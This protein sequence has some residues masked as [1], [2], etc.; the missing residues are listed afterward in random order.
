MKGNEFLEEFNEKQKKAILEENKKIFLIAGAGCG[1]TKTLIG[2]VNYLILN[3]NVK[4]KEILILTF[5]KKAIKEIKERIIFSLNDSFKDIFVYNFHSF[6]FKILNRYSYLIGFENN[7]FLVYDKKEQETLIKNI[8]TNEKLETDRKNINNIIFFIN[9]IKNKKIDI[10]KLK[11]DDKRVKIYEEYEKYF[12]KNKLFDYNDLILKSLKILIENPNIRKKYQDDFQHIFIDEFQDINSIQWE[13]I[14][15]ILGNN[16][17][18]FVVGDPNQSI[19]GFQGSTPDLIFSF[20]KN[21]SWKIIYLNENYRSTK[22]IVTFSN[23]FV[24]NNK[25]YLI[26]NLLNTNNEKGCKIEWLN[27]VSIFY[28]IRQIKCLIKEKKINFNDIAILYRNNYL[29]SKIEQNLINE[30]I[31]YEILGSYKFIEREEIKDILSFFKIISYEDNLSLKRIFSFQEK[32]GSRTI[33]KIEKESKKKNMNI[34]DFFNKEENYLGNKKIFLNNNQKKKIK[35]II[36]KINLWK[37]KIKEKYKIEEFL[38][39]IIED[40]E[41][42]KHLEKKIDYRERKKNIFQFINITKNWEKKNNKEE[43]TLEE[44]ISNFLQWLIISFEDKKM[45]KNRNNLIL[46]SI[47]Q[48]KGLEFE[49]VF[50]VYLDEEI[51]PNKNSEDLIEEKRLFYVG[52]TRAKKILYLMNSKKNYSS[53]IKETNIF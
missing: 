49:I 50:L 20:L 25:N 12:N 51:I 26:N 35:E 11:K 19:Y 23:S 28:I 29:S 27:C 52:I 22:K 24:E 44:L 30:K 39:N 17:S 10:N 21:K 43:Q 41:Y 36:S 37:K 40:F 42:W 13:I 3:K 46:S 14:N 1:K 32:I 9:N 48:S 8:L 5:T 15:I 45:L 18:I 47:H 31:P 6:C 53:L 33:S 4:C 38:L 34:Y 16:K 7:K 2:R